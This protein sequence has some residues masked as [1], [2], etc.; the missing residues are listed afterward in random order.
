MAVHYP[1]AHPFV[2]PVEHH[3][4]HTFDRLIFLLNRR[5]VELLKYVRDTREDKRA[6]ERERIE[7]ISQLT[8]IQEQLHIDLRQNVLQPYKMKWIGKLECK[9][10]QTQLNVPVEVQFKLKCLMRELERNISRLGEILELP[11]YV[12]HYATCHIP[13]VAT[14]KKG[15]APGEFY[16]ASGVAIHDETHQVFV[17]NRTN[18]RVEIF[19][20]TG[21][22]LY[23]LGVGELSR[24]WGI[25][26][27]GDS[28]YV[29]CWGDHSVSKFSLTEMCHVRRIGGKGSNNG[30][31][32][33]P[34]QLTTD[35][36]GCVFI[37]DTLNNRICIHDPDLNHLCNITHQSMSRPADIKVSRDRLY[38]L[39]PYNNPCIHVLTL[40]GDKLHSL[41]ACGEGMDV[42]LPLFFCLDPLNNFVLSDNKSHSIRVFS[43][44]G[45]LL[46][47]IG[48]KGDQPGMFSVPIGVA[49][50]L[51]GR[52]VCVS[53]NE[54]NGLQIFY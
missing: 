27:H 9:K 53:L 49:I 17:A 30:Q 37:A 12:P 46:H 6:A 44:E 4:N 3:I 52:L 33:G 21:E 38:V 28:V 50:T 36:I 31:F 34:N 29:S 15:R 23:Q 39:S 47:T 35:P 19:S 13:V 51:N 45:N 5:R 25:T 10:R 32:N 20:E 1:I 54:N 11:V 24:P 41:I 18:D 22:F 8:A 14:G 26:I 40:E 7:T 16:G 43:P 42:L 2:D 48:R